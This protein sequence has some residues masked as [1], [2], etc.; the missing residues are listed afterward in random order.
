MKE[1]I[2]GADAQ[3]QEIDRLLDAIRSLAHFAI[4]HK[5]TGPSQYDMV[6]EAIGF[7]ESEETKGET[8]Q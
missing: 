7:I 1:K 5:R 2:T 4:D 6:R 3:K 8:K